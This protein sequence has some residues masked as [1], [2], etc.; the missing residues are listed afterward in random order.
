MTKVANPERA[1][2]RIQRQIDKIGRLRGSGPNPFDYDLWD[3]R[4]VEILAAIYGEG[5]PELQRYYEAAGKRGR[6]PGVRGQAEN[7]T[8]NIH[9]PWGIHARLE[10]AERVLQE[11]VQELERAGS[12]S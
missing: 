4:T 1:K 9:G 12:A 7:M 3:D 2:E 11:L 8:L 6:L 5:S 10:R